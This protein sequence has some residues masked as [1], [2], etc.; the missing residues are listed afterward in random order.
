LGGRE[1][2]GL[3]RTGGWAEDRAEDE[4]GREDGNLIAGGGIHLGKGTSLQSKREED[5][6]DVVYG[7]EQDFGS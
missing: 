6:G 5:A 7:I 1:G 4:D 3:R 2:L